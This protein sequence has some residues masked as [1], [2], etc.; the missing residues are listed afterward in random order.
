MDKFIGEYFHTKKSARK[1]LNR[2]KRRAYRRIK[3]RGDIVLSDLSFV[4]LEYAWKYNHKGQYAYETK[5]LKWVAHLIIYTRNMN[6]DLNKMPLF[7]SAR[8]LEEILHDELS[9]K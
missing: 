9:E 2:R 8:E 3:K 6:D 7:D 5:I 4:R 1:D